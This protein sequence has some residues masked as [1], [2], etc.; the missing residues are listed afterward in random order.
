MDML[1]PVSGGP[2]AAAPEFGASIFTSIQEF[3][4]KLE[5]RKT[6][7]DAVVVDHAEK[8]STGN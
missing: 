4:L 8:S 3:G 2:P 6:A 7:Q 5:G 1:K